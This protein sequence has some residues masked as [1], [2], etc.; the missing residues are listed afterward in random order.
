M[1]TLTMKKVKSVLKKLSPQERKSCYI[2]WSIENGKYYKMLFCSEPEVADK[3]S[4][5]FGD[6]H[7]EGKDDMG[8]YGVWWL[9]KW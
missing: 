4:F 5:A 7:G 2:G 3:L 8:N 9:I 1:K 6:W